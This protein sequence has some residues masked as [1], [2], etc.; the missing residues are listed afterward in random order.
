MG[1]ATCF[2][3]M[4]LLQAATYAHINLCDAPHRI[5]TLFG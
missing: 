2:A 5:L 3:C 4:E 1:G